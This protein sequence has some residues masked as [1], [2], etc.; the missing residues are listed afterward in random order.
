MGQCGA[1]IFFREDFDEGWEQRWTKTQWKQEQQGPFVWTKGKW[2]GDESMA[3]GIQTGQDM[4]FYE[5]SSKL[6]TPASTGAAPF[7]LQYSVKFEQGIDCGGGYIKLVGPDYDASNF[8]GD[9][10]LLVMVGPDICGSDNKVHVVLDYKGK[11][12][13]WKKKPAALNDKLTHIYTLVLRPNASYEVYMDTQ[14]LGNGTLGEDWDFW[15]P[16]LIPDPTDK[17][18]EVELSTNG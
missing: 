7:V 1:K 14:P 17:K 16:K 3:Y 4:K 6:K 2:Y 18:P 13:L 11:G 15:P 10:P 8:G 9:T 5:I 12:Y